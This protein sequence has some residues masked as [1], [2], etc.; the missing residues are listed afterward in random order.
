M[1][2][3]Y[4]F[5]HQNQDDDFQYCFAKKK[6]Y[7]LVTLD[8]H[9]LNDGNY[10]IQ[11]IPGIIVVIAGRNQSSQITQS[12]LMF[13]TFLSFFPF[14]KS[15]LGDSKFQVSLEGCVMRARDAKTRELKTLT[16]TPGDTLAKVAG[17][18]HYFG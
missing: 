16:V 2:S 1:H 6:G 3:V 9:F 17:H 7:V 14:P 4:D 11:K 15:F 8:K 18:Y 12:L 5:G 10:P 13:T